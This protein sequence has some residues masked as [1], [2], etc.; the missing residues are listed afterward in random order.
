MQ[1]IHL[2]YDMYYARSDGESAYKKITSV[3]LKNTSREGE[4][5]RE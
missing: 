5:E 4:R 1:Q 2:Y 3:A